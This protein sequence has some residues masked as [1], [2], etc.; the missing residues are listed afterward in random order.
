M[1]ASMPEVTSIDI[2][3]PFYNGVRH[4]RPL[5]GSLDQHWDERQTVW[6]VNDGSDATQ[7][8][9]VVEAIKAHAHSSSIH[10]IDNDTNLGFLQTANKGISAG[11]GEVVVLL[12]SDTLVTEGW[13]DGLLAALFS[14]EDVGIVCPLSSHANFTRFPIPDGTNYRDVA[15]AVRSHSSREY[16]QIGIASGFCFA[17]RRSLFEELEAFDS[18]YGRGYYEE[19]DFCMRA[20]ERGWRVVAADDTFVFH[21]GWGTFGASGRNQWMDRNRELFE[22]RWGRNHDYWKRRFIEDAPFRELEQRVKAELKKRSGTTSPLLSS[23]SG[24]TWE[25]NIDWDRLD[26]LQGVPAGV[27]SVL[28]VLPGIGAYGGV[29]SVMQIVNR[30]ILRGINANVATYGPIDLEHFRET[31]YFR[32]HRGNS[33]SDLAANLPRYDLVV[34]TRWDTVFDSLLLCNSWGSGILAFVQDYEPD[35]YPLESKERSFAELA[36][37]LVEQKV[38]KTRWLADKLADYGGRTTVIPL[39][40]DLDVFYR[41]SGAPPSPPRI[42]SAA[43]PGVEYRNLEGTVEI[44]ELL[45]RER[46]EVIPTFYGK[47]F[48]VP[49]GFEHLGTLD[50]QGV[51]D[52]IRQSSVL[53]DASLFQ[54]FGRPGL[55]AMACG[56]PSVLTNRGGINEYARDGE[57]CLQADPYDAHAFVEAVLRLLDDEELRETVIEGG[58]ETA[59]RFSAEAEA[60]RWFELITDPKEPT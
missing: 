10:L 48:D 6:L 38:V 60:D 52:A 16:P 50:Q 4:V 8:D 57:N 12:N 34:A 3:V 5:L 51:A 45:R 7:R 28:F 11:S 19:A 46:S 49:K 21:Q 44:M 13:L 17:A 35:F 53:V 9:L 15:K 54:G 29:I 47:P 33:L 1:R 41:Q 32:P 22:R 42:I 37:R 14:S 39:G 58:V 20:M 36:L 27:E 25:A 2:V 43:R 30:L 55:E 18:I 40:L 24:P 31:L 26:V 59:S 56:V 23:M